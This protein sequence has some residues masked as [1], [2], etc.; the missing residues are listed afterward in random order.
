VISN[1]T[2]LDVFCCTTIARAPTRAPWQTS[3]TFSLSKVTGPQ[4]A[5][6]AETEQGQFPCS[7]EDL[8]P[9]RIAQISLSL[10]GNF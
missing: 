4:L 8:K 5:I 3:R 7:A 6:D 1:R 9:D 10:K 2:G